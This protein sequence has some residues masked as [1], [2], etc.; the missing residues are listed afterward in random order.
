[1]NELENLERRLDMLESASRFIDVLH[2]QLRWE[3]NIILL[4]QTSHRD[5]I[6]ML[7]D[8]YLG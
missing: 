5:T 8:E 7:N 1:M 6:R 3:F 2:D 4:C